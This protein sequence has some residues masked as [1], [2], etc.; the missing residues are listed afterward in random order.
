MR[1]GF[2]FLLVLGVLLAC[3]KKVDSGDADDISETAQ[4]VGDV[5]ASID[6]TGRSTGSIAMNE[7]GLDRTFA[8]MGYGPGFYES[9]IPDAYAQ[10]CDGSSFSTCSGNGVTRN[11]SGCTVGSAT[12]S[13][14]VTLTWG[15]GSSNCVLSAISDT[16]T[17]VPNF[18]V[19]GRRGATLSVT[20]S[21]S[22]GQRLT[23]NSGSGV[24][25]VFSFTNDGIRRVFT[26]PSGSVLFDL[27]TT[28]QSPITVTGVAR[29]N[30]NMNGGTLRVT[31]NVSGVTC[32]FSPSSVSWS[33][34]CNCPTTG[35][36]SATCSD[37]KTSVLTHT[38]CGTANFTL[39][40]NS[41]AVTLDRC[42]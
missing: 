27:T 17:R 35:S 25:K 24:N 3:S 39:G 41:S 2:S 36:W 14:T 13:G 8:R 20:K 12:F 16:L 15:G 1:N 11:F 34:G 26:A 7:R 21:G 31:N 5:V 9:L 33:A 6:E 42:L 40:S 4:Q 30:R 23:W 10:N 29:A 38:G 22:T 28:T 19:A 37:G 18:T 32:D